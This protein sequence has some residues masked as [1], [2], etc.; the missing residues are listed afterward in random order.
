LVRSQGVGCPQTFPFAYRFVGETEQERA[1]LFRDIWRDGK[2]R[3]DFEVAVSAD[4]P[5][6]EQA[7]CIAIGPHRDLNLGNWCCRDTVE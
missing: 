5:R 7:R 4:E 1:D 3:G 2:S 6:A